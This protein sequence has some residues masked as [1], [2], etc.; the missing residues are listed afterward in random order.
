MVQAARSA[1]IRSMPA[2]A[3]TPMGGRLRESGL[4]RGAALPPP[5]AVPPVRVCPGCAGSVEASLEREVGL[6]ILA[7]GAVLGVVERGRMRRHLDQRATS[8]DVRVE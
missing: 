4:D 8:W 7:R 1:L 6:A 5:H 3:M 2:V